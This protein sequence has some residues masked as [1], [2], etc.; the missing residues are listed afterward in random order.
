M[1]LWKEHILPN[2]KIHYLSVGLLLLFCTY[3]LLCPL[4][5]TLPS[6]ISWSMFHLETVERVSRLS[7]NNRMWWETTTC[8]IYV[9][10]CFSAHLAVCLHKS[11][12]RKNFETVLARQIIF[13]A[14]LVFR[15]SA[16]H[17]QKTIFSTQNRRVVFQ[18]PSVCKFH[19]A[20]VMF[21]LCH[22]KPAVSGSL[23]CTYSKWRLSLSFNSL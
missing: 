1:H 22:S 16:I 9:S 2:I 10:E 20:P 13:W 18:S 8:S 11:F 17:Y 15:W 19:K 23:L 21:F 3:T 4:P 14:A 5:D 6:W 7:C 12:F